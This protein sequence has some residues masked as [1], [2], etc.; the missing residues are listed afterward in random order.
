[1]GTNLKVRLVYCPI[2]QLDRYTNEPAPKC[3]KCGYSMVT[4]LNIEPLP[5][6]IFN[7]FKK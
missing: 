5:N 7:Q 4:K 1:M 6:S 2:C 3:I